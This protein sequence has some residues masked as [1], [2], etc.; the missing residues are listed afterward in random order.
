[1]N[2]VDLKC[3]ECD[4]AP[5]R[6]SSTEHKCC[7]APWMLRSVHARFLRFS[8]NGLPQD[9]SSLR[10]APC[11]CPC[12]RHVPHAV[13]RVHMPAYAGRATETE[14]TLFAVTMLCMEPAF[15]ALV[16]AARDALHASKP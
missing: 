4:G 8:P 2:R 6:L 7:I 9:L 1:M 12:L 15:E 13:T 16:R 11:S 10:A 5:E 3:V 14:P